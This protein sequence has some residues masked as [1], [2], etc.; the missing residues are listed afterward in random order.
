MNELRVF[1][2]VTSQETILDSKQEHFINF[3]PEG[4]SILL[5]KVKQVFLPHSIDI[6]QFQDNGNQFRLRKAAGGG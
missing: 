4:I 3:T 2:C 6:L 5:G 1:A